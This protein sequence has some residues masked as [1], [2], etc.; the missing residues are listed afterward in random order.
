MGRFNKQDDS[1][2]RLDEYMAELEKARRDLE[3]REENLRKT[4]NLIGYGII[5]GDGEGRIS[6]MNHIAQLL[7][8]SAPDEFKGNVLTDAFT[9]LSLPSRRVIENPFGG[10]LASGQVLIGEENALLVNRRGR[11]YYVEYSAAPNLYSEDNRIEGMVLVLRDVTE[12]HQR[13]EQIGQIQKMD[14]VGQLAGGIA[15]DFNNMLGGILGAA[16]LLQKRVQSDS[17]SYRIQRDNHQCHGTG[18]RADPGTGF[19]CHP[20][21]LFLFLPG[22]PQD[23]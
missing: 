10:V 12:Q 6:G 5:Y 13:Y 17:E 4:I 16:E 15:H 9:L 8:E 1:T 7:T 23:C 11:E 22:Y 18:R 14:V 2:E 3:I 20:A 21:A 19:L